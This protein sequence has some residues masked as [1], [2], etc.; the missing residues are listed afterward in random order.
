MANRRRRDEENE[1]NL[2]QGEEPG[3]SETATDGYIEGRN[4]PFLEER[5]D[6]I[7]EH[8]DS[9][10]NRSSHLAGT[11]GDHD[12]MSEK[13]ATIKR[14]KQV[15]TFDVSEVASNEAVQK[16]DMTPTNKKAQVSQTLPLQDTT[17]SVVTF[18][19]KLDVNFEEFAVK[20]SNDFHNMHSAFINDL[21]NNF[22][23]N[24]S[25]VSDKLDEMKSSITDQKNVTKQLKSQIKTQ[26]N[27]L[28]NFYEKK[29]NNYYFR[30]CFAGYK[31][32]H[33]AEKR[34]SRVYNYAQ[35]AV[36]RYRKKRWFYAF[37]KETHR[38]FKEHVMEMKYKIEKQ[39]RD[40]KL[41]VWTSK[42]DA[43][44]RY[45]AQLEEKI[46]GEI[47]EREELA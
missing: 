46:E 23:A 43:L 40:E 26:K 47:A 30:V 42:V 18:N 25:R 13:I 6:A 35:N 31:Y 39:M 9:E 17:Q 36:A 8:P 2:R 34:K 1:N 14:V 22:N 37:R 27:L 19:K 4:A 3:L 11:I 21:Q 29:T 15:G 32:F 44:K 33:K 12:I 38:K 5:D 24:N 16:S 10:H 28:E 41:N 45:M 20:V 7:S